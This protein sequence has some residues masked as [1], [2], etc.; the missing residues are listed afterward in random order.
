[1]IKVTMAVPAGRGT[2]SVMW[3]NSLLRTTQWAAKAGVQLR[4]MFLEGCSVISMARAR[5]AHAFRKNNDDAI[6]YVDDD[7]VWNP[8]DMAN[9]IAGLEDYD[10]CVG[11]YPAR[12]RNYIK[13]MVIEK[14]GAEPDSEGYIPI[15]RAP[16]GFMALRRD[17]L[18]K[19]QD[20]AEITMKHEGEDIPN[21]WAECLTVNG[22]MWTFSDDYAFCERWKAQDLTMGLWPNC[23]LAH[24]MSAPTA[25]T[26]LEWKARMKETENVNY[27]TE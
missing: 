19:V 16:G 21:P 12:A 14:D 6:I 8:E 23:N 11:S 4:P 7:V 26:Y 3:V 9:V 2:M 15:K 25:I 20:A 22:R 13:H 27:S 24:E 18:L 17:A 5:L 10:M 1:M